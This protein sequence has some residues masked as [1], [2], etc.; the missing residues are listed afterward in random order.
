MSSNRRDFIK[1]V[2]AGAAG[3]AAG[4]SVMGMSAKSYGRIIG[5]NERLN[6][7]IVG[8]GRR[9]GA[10]YQPVALKESNVQLLYLCDVMKSQRERAA[11]NFAKHID[12]E[13]GLVNDLRKVI[14]DP[15]VD[16]VFN[17]TP[18]HWHTPGSIMAI[19]GG[20]HVYVEKP[21]SHNM[22]ENEMLVEAGKKYNKV[23]QMGNQQRSSDHTIEI[24][25]EIHDGIIGTPYK[26][27]AFYT[28]RRGEV[29]VQK[30][31]PVPEGLDWA[32]FQGP[33]PRREYTSE[34]WNYNWH[35]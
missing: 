32:L 20:K 8:L 29:P 15:D 35:W 16:A 9:L 14:D 11:R 33:A 19:K 30:K 26:A 34:T 22:D 5:A 6:V 13:P 3:V 18:D 2:T 7:A 4:S 27:V 25:R 21:C 17:A 28:N 12:Y 1:K 31:A 23:V 24:I 10:F